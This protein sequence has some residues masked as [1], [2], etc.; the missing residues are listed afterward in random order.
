MTTAEANSYRTGLDA[1]NVAKSG[2][3]ASAVAAVKRE[4]ETNNTFVVLGP[5]MQF[6]VRYT[7]VFHCC[8]RSSLSAAVTVCAH[9]ATKPSPAQPIQTEPD[10]IRPN[11]TQPNPIRPNPT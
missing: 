6:Q 9:D 4:Q 2:L 11:P 8:E 5:L 10:P 3:T 1:R 7:A